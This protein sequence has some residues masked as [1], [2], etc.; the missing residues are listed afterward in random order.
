MLF[1]EQ[2]QQTRPISGLEQGVVSIT[3]LVW[4]KYVSTLCDEE[5]YVA[6]NGKKKIENS[7]NRCGVC[8]NDNLPIKPVTSYITETHL[9]KKKKQV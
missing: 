6:K 4:D 3:G 1:S 8:I 2:K 5:P 7:D 9:T